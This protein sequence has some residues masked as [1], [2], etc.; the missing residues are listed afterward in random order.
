MTHTPKF[1]K[2]IAV[3][4]V[5]LALFFISCRSS[6]NE[7]S[8]LEIAEKYYTALNNSDTSQ[9]AN[10]LN[11]S[12]VIR[13]NESNYQETFSQN[14]Y[15]ELMKWD[16]VFE[17]TYQ[18]LE[19]KQENGLVKTKISKID[20]RI[21][22]LH[23]EPMVWNEVIQFDHQ[24]IIKIER[25]R[26]EVFKVAKF[27]RNRDSLVNWIDINHPELNGFI[28]DQSEKGGLNY[29]QAIELYKTKH[30]ALQTHP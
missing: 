5:F 26:Y 14:G 1:V 30:N 10:L 29:L 4:T 27:L 24:K 12:I 17:P 13:E 28:I 9:V 7:N 22:F 15:V 8:R 3:Q 6:E 16:S 18:I 11:D 25:V 19:I 23:E 21:F 2:N 20:K